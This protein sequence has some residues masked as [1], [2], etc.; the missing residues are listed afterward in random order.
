[1]SAIAVIRRRRS[2]TV[3]RRQIGLHR[4]TRFPVRVGWAANTQR[5]VLFVIAWPQRRRASVLSVKRRGLNNFS[6]KRP[7]KYTRNFMHISMRFGGTAA[8][9]A[10]ALARKLKPTLRLY[11]A[12]TSKPSC[13]PARPSKAS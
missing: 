4:F 11:P 12:A 1:M 10:V 3:G 6:R 2:G 13:C 7:Q 5:G 9:A 8:A